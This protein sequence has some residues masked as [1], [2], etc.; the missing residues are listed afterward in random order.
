MI[1][2]H[3]QTIF[4][5]SLFDIFKTNNMYIDTLLTTL[6]FTMLNKIAGQL[7]SYDIFTLIKYVNFDYCFR[8]C[9]CIVLTGDRL[10]S[11]CVYT[12]S[13]IHI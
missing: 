12:L 7:E 8:K 10:R 13:L 4:S 6:A 3:L 2:L 9:A 5:L 11:V 1:P